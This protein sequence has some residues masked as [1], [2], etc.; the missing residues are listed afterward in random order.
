MIT[1]RI[2]A[3][4]VAAA[5]ITELVDTK[6]VELNELEFKQNYDA[7]LLKAA[8]AIANSGGGFIVIGIVEDDH[9]CATRIVNIERAD[10]VADSVRQRLRDGLSPRPSIE[11]VILPI[12]SDT[13]IVIRIAPQ[14]PPHMVSAD[15]RSDFYN[16][17]DATSERMRYEEIEQRFREKFS[18]GQIPLADFPRSSL[19]TLSGR[20]EFLTGTGNALS[21]YTTKFI[22]SKQSL[23]GLIA[24]Q[25]SFANAVSES[26]AR[27][28][29]SE[30][31]YARKGGWT[32][33]HTSL[34]L[35]PL[36][37]QWQ[38]DY[39]E[40]GRTYLNAS[41]DFVFQKAVDEVLC[42]RQNVTDFDRQPRLYSNALIEYCL[43]FMYSV[44]D[45]ASIMK[46]K[47]SFVKPVLVLGERGATLPLGEGGTVWFDAP[48]TAPHALQGN[49]S[50]PPLVVEVSG[51]LRV[52]RLAFDLAS[53]I[54]ALFGYEES[55]VA[56]SDGGSITFETS[57]D[58][59][60]LSA[61]RSY[62]RGLITYDVEYASFD[63]SKGIHWFRIRPSLDSREFNLIGFSEEFVADYGTSEDKLFSVLDG[64]AINANLPTSTPQHRLVVKTS[65]LDF[66]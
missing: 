43:S 39:G 23:F 52:R 13:V 1:D 66:V 16:R 60:T 3:R 2:S 62:L 50:T 57:T 25:E 29:F 64:L 63:H 31:S 49:T 45:I 21:Q 48:A 56:F 44:A 18:Q 36:G 35:R 42:W 28:V 26:T 40:S 17:Y 30:P 8:C 65:G 53:Q 27:L 51:P 7:D 61:V 5:D 33:I 10:S 41:G 46:P 4:D 19:E 37:G 54:Y 12:N 9:H 58:E 24:V 34:P 15:K 38:Q 20:R 59:S 6:Q 32:V 55:L 22:D 47:R 11:V 14:N